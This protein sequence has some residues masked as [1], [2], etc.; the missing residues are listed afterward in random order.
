MIETDRLKIA[1]RKHTVLNETTLK[2]TKSYTILGNNGSGKSSFAKAISGLIPYSGSIKVN[3]KEVSQTDPKELAKLI[4]YIP[5]KLESFDQ[6]ITLFEFVLLSRYAYKSRFFDFSHSDREITKKII[7]SLGLEP[8]ASKS[9][10]SLSSGESA[11]AL[12]ATALATNSNIMIFDEPTAN[13]DPKN[14]KKIAQ[15]IKDLLKR[16]QILL[17]THNITFARFMELDILF[18][19]D[20]RLSFYEYETFFCDKTLSNL[21]GVTFKNMEIFYEG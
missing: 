16:H 5:P 15:I 2:L 17:I 8:L 14:S 9:I 18:I 11:L 12:I 1:Y 20:G 7:N 3:K 13:L 4:T 6:N 19:Q 21:Y 10:G